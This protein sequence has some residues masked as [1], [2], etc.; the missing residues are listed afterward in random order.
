MNELI[1]TLTSDMKSNDLKIDNK[2]YRDVV[3]YSNSY[4]EE[5]AF[6]KLVMTAMK[7]LIE[8]EKRDGVINDLKQKLKYYEKEYSVLAHKKQ[9]SY[10]ED[11]K[12]R[13]E[14]GFYPADK[15]I[16]YELVKKLDAMGMSKKEIMNTLRISRSTVYRKL[17][18]ADAKGY[19]GEV[20]VHKRFNF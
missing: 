18:E 7:Y 15:H 6:P 3:M 10:A 2:H 12:Q 13:K 11:M 8:I 16:S 1:K 5:D 4:T 14:N 17:K 19:K 20:D 9:V